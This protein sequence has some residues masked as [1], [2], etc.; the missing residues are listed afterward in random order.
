MALKVLE[1]YR[2]NRKLTILYD[3][4]YLKGIVIK[5]S[6]I[7][8]YRN[9]VF[10]WHVHIGGDMWYREGIINETEKGNIKINSNDKIEI[11]H[12][13][14][15]DEYYLRGKNG[16]VIFNSDR[17][18]IT[19]TKTMLEVDHLLILEHYKKL[20]SLIL[21]LGQDCNE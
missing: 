21:K 8:K 17:N 5:K 19:D 11:Y 15:I 12:N 9:D 1:R 7:L 3:D 10:K 14:L 4:N 2:S 6:L 16:Y 13:T 20:D 18:K